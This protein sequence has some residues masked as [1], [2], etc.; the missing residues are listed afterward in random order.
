MNRW[1]TM[2]LDDWR[3]KGLA[4]LVAALLWLAIRHAMT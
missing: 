3:A 4:L 2:F 1:K